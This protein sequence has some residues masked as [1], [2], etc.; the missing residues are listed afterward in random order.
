[1]PPWSAQVADFHCPHRTCQ[2]AGLAP[3]T[4][5]ADQ[6]ESPVQAKEFE[7]C[8]G[9]AFPPGNA[10]YWASL[11][12]GKGE[13]KPNPNPYAGASLVTVVEG[14]AAGKRKVS[15]VVVAVVVDHASCA[16]V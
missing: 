6:S 12:D 9:E 16:S 2:D 7:A 10:G 8:V 4:E 14:A 3:D 11:E 1:M 13:G 15:A 5:D